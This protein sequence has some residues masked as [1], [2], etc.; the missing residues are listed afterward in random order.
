[1]SK[2]AKPPAANR[3]QM[4]EKDNGESLSHGKDST[5]SGYRQIMF[6]GNGRH[7]ASVDPDKTL[8]KTAQA[9]KHMLRRPKGWAFDSAILEAA[10][11]QGAIH[12]EVK[13]AETGDRYTAILADFRRYGV[14]LDRGHGE[15]VC[16]PLA[17]WHVQR[18][19]A[20]LQLALGV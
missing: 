19:G 4:S 11:K 8:R 2:N 6:A 17:Y 12:C 20:P 7:V 9:S 14:L 1:M 16:L 10:E 5:A 3:G 18:P 13:D 15:Q